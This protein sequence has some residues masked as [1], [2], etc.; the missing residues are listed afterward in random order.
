MRERS[1]KPANSDLIDETSTSDLHIV[2]LD[3]QQVHACNFREQKS[4]SQSWS[5]GLFEI[6]TNL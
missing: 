2:S 6:L 1:Q 5:C 3:N 4:Q